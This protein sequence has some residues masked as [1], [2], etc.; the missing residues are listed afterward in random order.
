ME[1]IG[2]KHMVKGGHHGSNCR[3]RVT[4]D[5]AIGLCPMA[6][7]ISHNRISTVNGWRKNRSGKPEGLLCFHEIYFVNPG[8]QFTKPGLCFEKPGLSFLEIGTGLQN[9][10]C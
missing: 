3:D 7:L 9:K 8:M 5:C 6:V 1:Y 10:E 4:P 2:F